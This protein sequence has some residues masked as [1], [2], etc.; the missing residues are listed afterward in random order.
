MVTLFSS[1]IAYIHKCRDSIPDYAIVATGTRHT[2]SPT[3]STPRGSCTG[4]HVRYLSSA[5]PARARADHRRLDGWSGRRRHISPDLDGGST[6]STGSLDAPSASH[7]RTFHTV[8]T[9][10]HYRCRR[11]G[12][13]HATGAL[14]IIPYITLV[15]SAAMHDSNN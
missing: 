14:T 6:A 15:S 8:Y 4:A 7:R 1:F 2:L 9:P 12:A 13:V 5:A 11:H 3:V 10:T